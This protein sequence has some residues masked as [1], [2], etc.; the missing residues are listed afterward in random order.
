MVYFLR[1]QRSLDVRLLDCLLDVNGLNETRVLF[2]CNLLGVT[3]SVIL[4]DVLPTDLV[5]LDKFIDRTYFIDRKLR[6][7]KEEVVMNLVKSG[8]LRGQR[9]KMGLPV[10]GQ[11]TH[12]NAS[13]A[14]RR[15]KI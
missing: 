2:L 8:S 3:R 10:R 9:R 7:V 1:K 15:N 13:T 12:T 4:K 14:R 5:W 6:R 11:R